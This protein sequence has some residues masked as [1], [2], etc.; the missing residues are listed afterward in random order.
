MDCLKYCASLLI[1]V[2]VICSCDNLVDSRKTIS[3]ENR[4]LKTVKIDTSGGRTTVS[5]IYKVRNFMFEGKYKMRFEF[6]RKGEVSKGG[7]RGDTLYRYGDTLMLGNA[8]EIDSPVYKKFSFKSR[9]ED[10]K[11]NDLYKGGLARPDF[12]T[13]KNAKYFITRIKEGCEN[14]KPDFAGHYTIVEW[15]CGSACQ[16]MAIVDR[17]NGKILFSKIPFDTADGHCGV[18]YRVDSRMLIVNTEALSGSWGYEPGYKRY[19]FWRV[20]AV[21]EMKNGQLKKVE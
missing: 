15:G 9:F 18:D 4:V 21:Y 5:Y 13:D 3:S 17:I 16:E 2:L 14:T 12:S 11:V 10:F 6:L 19:D 20:P 8:D 1:M 7:T